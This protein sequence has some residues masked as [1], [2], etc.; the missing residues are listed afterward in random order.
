MSTLEEV[1][2]LQDLEVPYPLA[3]AICTGAILLVFFFH[4]ELH[5]RV[6][7]TKQPVARMHTLEGGLIVHSVLIGFALG[8]A[9]DITGL[10]SLAIAMMFHQLCE[11]FAM[12]SAVKEA[13]KGA[14]GISRLHQAT[15]VLLFALST[16]AGVIIGWLAVPSDSAQA[17][18][19]ASLGTQ[20]VL[21]A[22][23]A[24][25]LICSALCEFL[26][27]LYGLAAHQHGTGA[28][29]GASPAAAELASAP[30]SNT[31]EAPPE[32]AVVANESGGAAEGGAAGGF[33]LNHCSG[34][35]RLVNHVGVSVG[36][37]A[38]AVLALW[39]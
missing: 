26:P 18:S 14:W 25:I 27:E 24:G 20:G 8:T 34:W 31:L 30:L 10:R 13:A 4:V 21:S 7:H 35:W 29:G 32:V 16:P 3:P 37:G 23:A 15:M 6:D 22:V 17:D 36:A 11:G 5:H 39:S 19:T 28:T 12:G 33:A 38:M 2:W 1:G 9:P